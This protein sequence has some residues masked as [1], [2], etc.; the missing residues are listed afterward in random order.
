MEKEIIA[1]AI[2]AGLL[3]LPSIIFLVI[4]DR[5]LRE[6][7]HFDLFSDGDISVYERDRLHFLLRTARVLLVALVIMIV[8]VEVL[9]LYLLNQGF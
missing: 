7:W 1:G 6:G 9:S 3:L 2:L 5:K 8:L 4:V